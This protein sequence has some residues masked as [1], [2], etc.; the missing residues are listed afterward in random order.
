MIGGRDE[1]TVN[2]VSK[3]YENFDAPVVKTDIRTAEMIKYASNAL[4]ATK[5]SFANELSRICEKVGIDV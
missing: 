4:L 5:I 3:A 2:K 1:K